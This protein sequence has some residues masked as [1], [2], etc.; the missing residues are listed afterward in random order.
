MPKYTYIYDLNTIS[1]SKEVFRTTVGGYYMLE[2]GTYGTGYEFE[3]YTASRPVSPMLKKVEDKGS[4]D[5]ARTETI[6]DRVI[7]PNRR[8]PIRIYGDPEYIKSDLHWRTFLSGG[9]WQGQDMGGVYDDSTYDLHP[10]ITALPQ[11]REETNILSSI[12]TWD[13]NM[14]TTQIQPSY[15]RYYAPYQQHIANLD[16]V[17]TIPNIYSLMSISML[18]KGLMEAGEAFGERATDDLEELKLKYDTQVYDFIS[19]DGSVS[20]EDVAE[21]FDSKESPMPG[22]DIPEFPYDMITDS[23]EEKADLDAALASFS[24]LYTDPDPFLRHYLTSSLILNPLSETT[25]D[26]VDNKFQHI[27]FAAG[28]SNTLSTSEPVLEALSLYPMGINIA[29]EKLSTDSNRYNPEE[30][31][32]TFAR[33]IKTNKF[34]AKFLKT[35][36]EVMMGEIDPEAVSLREVGTAWQQYYNTASLGDSAIREISEVKTQNVKY[37]DYMKFL[38]HAYTNY[39]SRTDNCYFVGSRFTPGVEWA[40]DMSGT[41]RYGNTKAVVGTMKDVVAWT[42]A[43]FDIESLKDIY[44]LGNSGPHDWEPAT[45]FLAYRIE[46]IGGPPTGDSSTENVLQ[47]IWIFNDADHNEQEFKYLDSQVKYGENYTYNIYAYALSIGIKYKFSD[48]RMTR[49]IGTYDTMPALDPS[50]L[51]ESTCLEFYD[52]ATNEPVAQ[53]FDTETNLVNEFASN[54]QITSTEDKYLADFY[55]NFE[56]SIKLIEIPIISKT[57]KVLDNPGTNL[58][59]YPFQ[60]LNNS[61]TVGFYLD[62]ETHAIEPYPVV[63][64]SAEEAYRASYLGAYDIPSGYEITPSSLGAATS[65]EVYRMDQKPAS[66]RSFENN[67]HKTIN[68]KA[69]GTN[70]TYPDTF[71][72]D[73][74]KT[75]TKYYYT[76]RVKT[77]QGGSGQLSE[78]Y[79]VQMVDDGGY[80]Y[81]LFKTLFQEDLVE[82]TYIEPSKPFKKLLQLQPNLSHLIM[83]TEDIDFDDSA[84]TQLSNLIV[85]IAEDSLWNKTFKIRLISKKTAKKVDINVTY[86]LKQE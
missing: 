39:T 12:G 15:K 9:T 40:M 45:E 71:F 20:D 7:L 30:T 49:Q 21:L 35:L 50:I 25:K 23:P 76:F 79:E 28:V 36:K 34:S 67:L 54:A 85:G 6:S 17:R 18:T 77:A 61:Q 74:I 73:R 58:T 69:I 8:F 78:I 19:L 38:T 43:Y 52:A 65:V 86:N 56:P 47:N 83:N 57:L 72:Y 80:K 70:Y 27:F 53:L 66:L 2:S 41:Y 10:I 63:L 32:E 81:S 3:S 26:Y 33:S 4:P 29:I 31:P 59:I 64:S 42:R 75:N 68:L 62:Y 82:E 16:S 48:L 84:Q 60:E 1:G 55:L 44:N 11:T 24:G 37:I 51:L 5:W 46:K 22:Q 13:G 14:M